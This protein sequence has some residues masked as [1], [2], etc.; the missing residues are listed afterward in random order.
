MRPREPGTSSQNPERKDALDG[1]AD[2]RRS[3]PNAARV[4]TVAP[5][6]AA[7]R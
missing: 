6:S 4:I 1:I 2:G 7:N 3:T 5:I